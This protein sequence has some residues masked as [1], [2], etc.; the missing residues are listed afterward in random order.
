MHE[1]RWRPAMKTLLVLGSKPEP[2]LPPP[3]SFD[4]IA[5]ANASGNS[6]AR[7]GLGSAR[8][9]VISAILTSA[10]KP[11]NRQALQA[12]RGLHTDM[13]FF[14]PRRPPEGNSLQRMVAHVEGYRNKSWYVRHILRSYGY[15]WNEFLHPGLPH[16]VELF[17]SLSDCNADIAALMERKQPSTGILA[18]AAGIALGGYGR[19]ILSGFSFEITHAYA[20]NP[21]VGERGVAS[22]HADTDIALL[23]YLARKLG[24]IY[25]T[26]PIV[27]QRAGVPLLQPVRS[28][29][30]LSEGAQVLDR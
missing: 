28:P 20:H 3:G 30:A 15:R 8:L 21:L 16:I 23:S 18:L 17:R 7:Y 2:M 24:T 4:D 6:A 27:E 9:T 29:S 5:C 1:G 22:R 14:Y 12:M 26:E 13:L 11:A 25:T 19:Y 10:S